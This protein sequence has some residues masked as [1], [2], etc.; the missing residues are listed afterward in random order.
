MSEVGSA[1]AVWYVLNLA[2]S[3][4]SGLQGLRTLREAI[5][6]SSWLEEGRESQAP[7]TGCHENPSAGLPGDLVP[8]EKAGLKA[9]WANQAEGSAGARDPRPS[10]SPGR[11]E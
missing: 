7:G 10:R 6:L 8:R 5:N 3:S 4:E 1:G 2:Y 11:V 9:G